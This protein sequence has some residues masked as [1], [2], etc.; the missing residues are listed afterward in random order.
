M[1]IQSQME[2][3]NDFI[4]ET[5]QEPSVMGPNEYYEKREHNK[6]HEKLDFIM[7]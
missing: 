5:R 2:E 6:L 3:N 1:T 4:D 7:K